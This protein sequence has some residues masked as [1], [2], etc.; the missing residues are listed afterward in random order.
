MRG[1]WCIPRVYPRC[2]VGEVYTQGVSLLVYP[3]WYTSLCTML[4]IPPCAPCWVYLRVLST[5]GCTSGV[6][7]LR[8]YLRVVTMLGVPQ[9]GDH[10]GCTSGCDTCV[11]ASQGVTPVYMPLRVVP[12]WVSLGVVP[13]WVYHPISYSPF[14]TLFTV[15]SRM[16]S[17]LGVLLG[18]EDSSGQE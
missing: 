16:A 9:G 18:F 4:G 17:S 12:G 14:Y 13:G 3:E 1:E 8:V 6:V 2:I 5:L 10:A 11:Y 15:L 7:N